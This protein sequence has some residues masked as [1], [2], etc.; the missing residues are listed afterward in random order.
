MAVQFL[1]HSMALSW[2][3]GHA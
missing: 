3:S 1:L 2:R